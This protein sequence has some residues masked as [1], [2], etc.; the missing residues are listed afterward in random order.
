MKTI[1]KMIF[2]IMSMVVG[3][4]VV[5]AKLVDT[6]TKANLNNSV[7]LVFNSLYDTENKIYFNKGDLY[8]K[9]SIYFYIYL[10]YLN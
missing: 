4:T 7:N 1:R 9:I 3:L 6:T 2:I 10:Y 8:L 5:E